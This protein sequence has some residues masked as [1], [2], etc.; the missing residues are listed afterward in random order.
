MITRV[1]VCG[2]RTRENSE[3][4]LLSKP[5]NAPCRD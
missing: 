4:L 5:A 2:A 3:V 1:Y